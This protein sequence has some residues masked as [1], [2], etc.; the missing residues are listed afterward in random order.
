VVDAW[1]V[2]ATQARS[3]GLVT[4]AV[5]AMIGGGATSTACRPSERC[6]AA[7]ALAAAA[8][9]DASEYGW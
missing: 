1:Q 4:A 2:L 6:L 5:Q 7:A 9:G 8:V 3:G